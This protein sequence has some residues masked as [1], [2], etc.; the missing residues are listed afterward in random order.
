M[1]AE[2]GGETPEKQLPAQNKT[3]LTLVRILVLVFVLALTLGLLTFRDRISSLGAYGYPGIFLLSILANATVIIPLPG[4]ILTSAMG[5]IFNPF[6]VAVAAGSGAGLGELTGYLAGFS[7]RAVVERTPWQLKLES[8]MRKYGDITIFLLAIIP[9]PFFDLAGI[10]AGA[11]R[12]P[13]WR[14]LLWCVL[15]KIIKMLAFAYLGNAWL[16]WL[17]SY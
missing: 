4:V 6:W 9:N 3:R 7:G 5:A 2:P 16:Q 13:V 1:S 11:L 8:W 17:P 15:G 14:F 10:T 12:V